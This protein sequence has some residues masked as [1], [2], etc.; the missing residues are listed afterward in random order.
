ML[1][2]LL[3]TGETPE[4]LRAELAGGH[5]DA[6]LASTQPL[7]W[8]PGKVAGRYLAPYLAKITEAAMPRF[9]LEFDNSMRIDIQLDPESGVGDPG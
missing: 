9:E 3:L 7:W 6:F 2:G 8:P 4:F 1:R 5:G